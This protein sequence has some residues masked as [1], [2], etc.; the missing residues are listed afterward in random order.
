MAVGS[1]KAVR[2]VAGSNARNAHVIIIP[3]HRVIG[4]DGSLTGYAGGVERK[5]NLLKAEGAFTGELL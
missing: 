4:K 2:A 1:E 5:L 3:C